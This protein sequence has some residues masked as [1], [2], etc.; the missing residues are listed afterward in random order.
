MNQSIIVVDCLGFFSL[1]SMFFRFRSTRSVYFLHKSRGIISRVVVKMFGNLGWS[2]EPIDFTM[3]PIGD[4]SPFK[5]FEKLLIEKIKICR[6]RIFPEQVNKLSNISHYERIRLLTYFG[7]YA[8]AEMYFAMQLYIFLTIKFPLKEKVKVV[9]LRKNLF[10]DIISDTY[11]SSNLTLHH[12]ISLFREK[13]I[14]REGYFFDKF[15]L[16][17]TLFHVRKLAIMVVFVLRSL[18]YKGSSFFINSNIKKHKICALVF[19]KCATDLCNCLPWGTPQINNLKNET[20]CL[21][22]PTMPETIR[23][24]YRE[25]SNKCIQYSLNPI[26]RNKAIEIRGAWSSFFIVF[27]KNVYTYRKL[28]GFV[29]VKLW[30]AKYLIDLIL[31][32]SFFESLFRFNGTK[33]LWTMNEDNTHTQMAAIAIQRIGGVS[34]GTTWSQVLFPVW[35]IQHNQHD[36]YFLWGK[37]LVGVRMN[38][39]DQCNSFVIAGYPADKLFVN[40]FQKAQKFRSSIIKKYAIK[41]ILTLYDNTSANDD[42][43]SA[44]KIVEMYTEIFAWLEECPLNFLIFKAKRAEILNKQP[45]IKKIIDDFC[46]KGRILVLFD[47]AAIYPSLAADVVI[48][49]SLT[50]PSVAA[51]LGWP[52]IF[53]DIHNVT[54]EYPLG[55]SNVHIIYRASEI[56]KAINNVMEDSHKKGYPKKLQPITGS[57]IDPF[58]D[59][60]A[61]FRMRKYIKNLLCKLDEGCTNYEAINF[62]N[63][64]HKRNWGKDTVIYGPMRLNNKISVTN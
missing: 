45:T 32:M 37:R 26:V 56:R 24:F 31:Y 62:A 48:G 53:Y 54:R 39:Y 12:Y 44:E 36:V 11:R 23:G 49:V 3:S 51:S 40:E 63:E 5:E 64:E 52:L 7:K 50:L 43:I 6:E 41:N 10:S 27:L 21:H 4:L 29:S 8:G 2:F 59:G 16:D 18:C 58:V 28:F 13:L 34:L 15:I 19:N 25:R 61:A 33:V 60:N 22:L 20:L 9:L 30:M 47:R 35:R 1:L 55:L 17:S 46:T 42:F 14:L 38:I 57:Y